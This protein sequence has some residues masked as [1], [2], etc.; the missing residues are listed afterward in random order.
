MGQDLRSCGADSRGHCPQFGLFL[1]AIAAYVGGW[2]DEIIMRLVDVLLAFPAIL[3]ALLFAAIYKPGTLTA[4]SAIGL[5]SVPIF[6]KLMRAAVLKVKHEDFVEGARALGAN[7]GP[8]YG[9]T[10]CLAPLRPSSCRIT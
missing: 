6:A 2:L 9:D 3:L 7:P 10:F 8:F 5:A 1:G 4:M